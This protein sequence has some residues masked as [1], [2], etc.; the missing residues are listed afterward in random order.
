MEEIDG[1][2]VERDGIQVIIVK[3]PGGGISGRELLEMAANI[4]LAEL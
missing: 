4:I 2:I 1:F 3:G